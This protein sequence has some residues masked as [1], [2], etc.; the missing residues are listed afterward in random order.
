[1]LIDKINNINICRGLEIAANNKELYLKLLEKFFNEDKNIIDEVDKLIKKADYQSAKTLIHTIKG[2]S[3]N[4]GAEQLN[5]I[6][7]KFEK[8]LNNENL[9]KIEII[10]NQF[11]AELNNVFDD[12]K[13]ILETLSKKDLNDLNAPLDEIL[14][15]INDD[16]SEA[17]D[18][19]LSLKSIFYENEL[20]NEYNK[21]VK[22]MENF[23]FN[24]AELIILEIKK[25]LNN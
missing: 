5:K 13:I 11:K 1:M 22:E 20:E 17:I 25:K 12:I 14:K 2:V 23:E 18:L 8:T 6:S 16:I 7:S 19:T 4:L 15:L 3:A 21:L 24:N 9:D 10:F